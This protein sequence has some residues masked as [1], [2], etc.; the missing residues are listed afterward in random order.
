M[1]IGGNLLSDYYSFTQ[2]SYGHRL[3][4]CVSNALN[5]LRNWNDFINGLHVTAQLTGNQVQNLGVSVL[6]EI[7]IFDGRNSLP[8]I[9]NRELRLLLKGF[10]SYRERFEAFLEQVSTEVLETIRELIVCDEVLEE[11]FIREVEID[12]AR[13]RNC[14]D[15]ENPGGEQTPAPTF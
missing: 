6:S 13:A 5:L 9:I 15:V 8:A 14:V 10:L 1:L 4:T 12:L 11:D 2:S 7:A 3:A